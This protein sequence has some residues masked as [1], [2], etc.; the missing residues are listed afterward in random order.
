MLDGRNGV[1]LVFEPF[2]ASGF[3]SGPGALLTKV[4]DLKIIRHRFR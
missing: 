3:G 1:G 2:G 4:C